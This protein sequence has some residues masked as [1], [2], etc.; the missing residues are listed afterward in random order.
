MSGTVEIRY[1]DIEKIPADC[2]V[3]AANSSL[4]FGGGVCGAIFLAAGKSE[5]A[6]ACQRLG[7]CPVG[8]VS[9]TPAFALPAKFVIHAVGPHT[10]SPDHAR[11][12]HSAYTEALDKAKE[13]GCRSISFPLISSGVFN[14]AGVGYAR[15]WEI[16]IS[17]VL[18][19]QESCADHGIDVLF[20]CHGKQLIR[21]GETVLDRLR[22]K[23]S[24]KAQERCGD[25]GVCTAG[26]PGYAKERFRIYASPS[27][28]FAEPKSRS[29]IAEFEDSALAKNYMAY[30][31]SRK[32][33]QDKDIV[34]QS[35]RVKGIA[36]GEQVREETATGDTLFILSPAGEY[37]QPEDSISI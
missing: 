6:A 35:V 32:R 4:A 24:G 21:E 29:F 22:A 13:L 30:M 15:L 20:V 10:S 18:E 11:L 17:A 25:P 37:F 23:A 3:N 12:L 28:Q 33:Y 8:G 16:A 9:V 27:G 34:L 14:D 2:I 19:H 36:L 5:M 1:G 26:H 31:R 7:H